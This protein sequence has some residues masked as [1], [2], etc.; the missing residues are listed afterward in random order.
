MTERTV[1]PDL[2]LAELPFPEHRD[3]AWRIL[4]ERGGSVQLD[5]TV[6]LT[7]LET[8]ETALRQPQLFSS[9]KAFDALNSPLPLVPVAF[10]PPEQTRYRRILQP[11]FSPRSIRPLEQPL[12]AQ[13]AELIDPLVERGGCDF[14]ADVAV[15]FPV[16]TFLTLFGLPLQDRDRFLLWKDAVLGLSDTSGVVRPDATPEELAQALGLFDYLGELI[17]RRRGEPGDDV[18]S[19]LLRLEGE[20]GLTDEE[21]I[22]L[23]FLFVLAGLET[24]TDA[25][26]FGMER[27]ATNPDRRDEL[28]TDPGIIPDAIEELVRLDPPAPF[29][30]RITTDET[31]IDGRTLP[32]GSRII[33]HLA[34]ANRDGS[35]RADPFDI[36]F[37]RGENPH[38]SFGVG[39]HRCLGSHLARLEM[40][41]VYEEWHRRIPRYRVTPGTTPRVKWPR[42]TLGLDALRLSFDE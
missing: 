20:D 9:R 35:R 37:H 12:R 33:A 16:Q 38:T 27:L 19:T 28:V 7:S 13:L 25:L 41:L 4:G 10:D 5:N 23:C 18:L 22:G 26:G 34:V 21:A 40:R 1:S 11:F 29:L 42:G 17:R 15:P 3:E 24:V 2:T 14:V 39:V 30:P 36:D 31:T 32:P 8:V 6:A